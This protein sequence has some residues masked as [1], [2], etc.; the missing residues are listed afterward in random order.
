MTRRLRSS[1]TTVRH[2]ASGQAQGF[3]GE[4]V[5]HQP[6]PRPPSQRTGPA[7][8]AAC[9]KLI[10]AAASVFV[11]PNYTAPPHPPGGAA[12]HLEN[13]R[14]KQRLRAIRRGRGRRLPPAIQSNS[15]PGT[16][17]DRTGPKSLDTWSTTTK[18]DRFG[19]GTMSGLSLRMAATVSRSRL[20]VAATTS[21]GVRPSH[22]F[23]DTSAK[24]SLRNSSSIRTGPSP[25]FS[26]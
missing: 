13:G 8:S 16:R 22:W 24:W 21:A 14:A 10:G 5:V 20:S 25:T 15:I 23:S 12:L 1:T 9:Y 2:P 18:L 11:V 3:C 26:M 7:G 19:Y 4:G 6:Q 17:A